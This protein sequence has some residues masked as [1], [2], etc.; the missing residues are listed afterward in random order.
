M[1]FDIAK[2]FEN[3]V[4][5]YVR[6]PLAQKIALPVMIA[7]SVMGILFVTRWSSRPEYQ[8]IYSGLS[9]ADAAG[10]IERLKDMKVNYKL[11][12]NSISISPPESV[13]EIRLE[14]ASSGLPKGGTTGFELFDK[15]QLGVTDFLEKLGLVRA[16][17]GE[18]ERTIMAIDSIKSVRVH[19]TKPDKSAFAK[20]E[21]LPTASVLLRLKTG[22]SLSQPQVKGI[23]HLVAGSIERLTPDNVTIMDAQGNLLNKKRDETDMSGADLTRLE[24]QQNIE[25][26]LVRRIETMLSEIL[27]P[28]HAVARVTADLDFSKFEKEEEAY[29]PAGQVMRSERTVDENGGKGAEGGVSGVVSNLTNDPNLLTGQDAA[30]NPTGHRES[31]KNYEV[32]R[33]VS[34]TSSSIGKLVRLSV[35]VL[36]DGQYV[37][38][39]TTV[40]G[41][42]GKPVPSTTKEFKALPAEMLHK[43]ENLVKQAVGF[44]A[45]RGDQ[46]TVENIR[47][48]VMDDTNEASLKAVE[49]RE[50]QGMYIRYGVLGFGIFLFFL[51]LVRPLVR[52]LVTPT[53]SPVDLTRLL[54]SGLEELEAELEAERGRLSSLPELGLPGVNME[55]LE[56]LLAENSK[57]VK[58]N[59]QQAALLI[60][61]WLNDGRL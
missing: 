12:G 3:I 28:G 20:T 55:E 19:I 1:K 2:V 52:F 35:A 22:M 53:E 40:T 6:M 11:D 43:I 9:D 29:D 17:Q 36:V 32:S 4:M 48:N 27:G 41:A 14:L 7:G 38:L 34:K 47:F 26:S 54:P 50:T 13:N 37:D 45:T 21:I 61:Y 46:V 18:L 16:L 44:D 24:Y 33:A 5:M 30:K 56:G 58:D 57:L 49:A 8:T 23:A 15:Q 25:T 51:V 39:P 59:P 42:D 31:V 10:V 60:R